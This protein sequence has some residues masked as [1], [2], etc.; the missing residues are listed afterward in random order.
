MTIG[1]TR[2]QAVV[3][4]DLVPPYPDRQS[5]GAISFHVDMSPHAA[6]H[7]DR[8]LPAPSSVLHV[9]RLL[10]RA[11]KENHAI[12]LESLCVQAGRY[13]WSI[14][15][16]VHI[17]DHDGNVLDASLLATT[18]ALQAFR[19][20]EV[21]LETNT[22]DFQPTNHTTTSATAAPGGLTIHPPT[23]REPL[24]L[25]LHHV[26]IAISLGI[27]AGGTLVAVDP[28]QAEEAAA[29]GTFT[30]VVHAEG[31]V[32]CVEKRGGV[33]LSVLQ[34]MR[35]VRVAGSQAREVAGKLAA[36]VKAHARARI[37][38]RVRRVAPV[39]LDPKAPG[40][41]RRQAPTMTSYDL[42]TP[43]DDEL[44]EGAPVDSS[45]TS[46]EDDGEDEEEEE[47]E[48]EEDAHDDVDNVHK[49]EKQTASGAVRVQRGVIPMP[50]RGDTATA[51]GRAI[52]GGGASASGG[53]NG[54]GSSS[55]IPPRGVYAKEKKGGARGEKMITSGVGAGVGADARLRE[56][57]AKGGTGTGGVAKRTLADAVST[58]ATRRRKKG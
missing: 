43:E 16:D 9:S 24:P 52:S 2:V 32:C 39:P 6:P 27:F 26:P 36:A 55:S 8:H 48:E 23:E 11:L 51:G 10:E 46:M 49:K 13:V 37:A 58:K 42:L 53:S 44:A 31:E 40:H 14:R 57:V 35:C 21:T 7:L 20:P 28:C 34:V 18:A 4:G 22:D 47:E 12:D 50:A 19:R 25:T 33:P 45:D 54:G 15:V 30:A 41:V 17:L 3:Y 5:E 56:A 1:A 38:H 29:E